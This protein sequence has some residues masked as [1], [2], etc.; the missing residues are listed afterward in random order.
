MPRN[1]HTLYNETQYLSKDLL[2]FITAGLQAYG[3]GHSYT[4]TVK[5]GRHTRTCSGYAWFHTHRIHLFVPNSRI[6]SDGKRVV[7]KQLPLDV[8]RALAGVLEHEI[9]H[10][11]GLKHR[12]MGRLDE[13]VGHW[14][15]E[16]R[17][18]RKVTISKPTP[19]ERAA[20]REEQT[21]KRLA[22]IEQDI[23]R[24]Q[25]LRQKWAAK[26]RYYDRKA[27]AASPKQK[28]ND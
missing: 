25:R 19:A 28:A 5:Y 2:Q 4:V 27:R 24:L 17:I 23:V 8:L 14:W 11:R 15:H 18:R 20:K 6:G 10:C 1:E 7:F 16:Q 9:D 13:N 3:D 22:D 12:E 21:R 26:V